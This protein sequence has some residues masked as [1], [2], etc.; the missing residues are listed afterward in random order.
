MGSSELGTEPSRADAQSRAEPSR[1]EPG[2]EPSQGQNR[3]RRRR[4]E[5][6]Q[7]QT[8]R[9]EAEPGAGTQSRAR[10]RHPEPS[11]AQNRAAQ[12]PRAEPGT[13]S[14]RSPQCMRESQTAYLGP[15]VR[16]RPFLLSAGR[17]HSNHGSINSCQPCIRRER[18]S[19]GRQAWPSAS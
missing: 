2:T 16:L 3:A 4:P 18:G 19:R 5:P 8:P 15:G 1:A 9:A 10:R 14:E 11:Q 6:S 17:L 13:S 12:T 7:A